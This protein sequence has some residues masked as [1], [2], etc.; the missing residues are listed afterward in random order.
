MSAAIRLEGVVPPPP[1]GDWPGPLDLEITEGVFCVICTPAA[2]TGPLLRL[3]AGLLEPTQGRVHVL[4]VE[5]ARLDRRE[6]QQFRRNLGVALQPGGLISNLT[7][8]MNVIVPLL[9]SGAADLDTASR[10]ADETLAAAGLASWA[11]FRPA[12]V[13]PDVRREAVVARAIARDPELLLLEDPVAS[14][15]TSQAAWLIDLCRQ[16]ARTALIALP[17]PNGLLAQFADMSASWD[18]QGLQVTS[19]E[20]GIV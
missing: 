2:L 3:C 1:C 15:R 14:L 4:G 18:E 13:P 10:R 17:E 9:Y 16:K 20:V 12:D 19:H 7:I 11:N 8:R 5:P 6:A